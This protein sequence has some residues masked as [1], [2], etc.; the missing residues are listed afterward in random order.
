ML[1]L[2]GLWRLPASFLKQTV[3]FYFSCCGFPS[4][5]V[6]ADLLYVNSL[7][8][9]LILLQV[10]LL[11]K[12]NWLQATFFFSGGPLLNSCWPDKFEVLRSS[13]G[14]HLFLFPATAAKPGFMLIVYSSGNHPRLT[15]CPTTMLT[16]PLTGNIKTTFIDLKWST[17]TSILLKS[18]LVMMVSME[19]IFF[20]GPMGRN[21]LGMIQMH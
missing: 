11:L 17:S 1:Y 10:V 4:A 15:V 19:D 9:G 14:I 21:S 3:M 5:L 20:S 12:F 2:L 13:Q 7:C 8:W 16:C 18:S 6:S